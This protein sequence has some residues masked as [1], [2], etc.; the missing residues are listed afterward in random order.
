MLFGLVELR[1]DEKEVVEY[2]WSFMGRKDDGDKGSVWLKEYGE[3][4]RKMCRDWFG[5]KMKKKGERCWWVLV[6]WWAGC[7]SR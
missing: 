3:R 4:E 5:E 6:M 2:C 1:G 7:Y